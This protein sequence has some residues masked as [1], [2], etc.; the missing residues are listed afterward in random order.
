VETF[1][2]KPGDC[3]SFIISSAVLIQLWLSFTLILPDLGVKTK[4]AGGQNQFGFACQVFDI[5]VHQQN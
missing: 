2:V 5:R 3:S 4:I 1:L